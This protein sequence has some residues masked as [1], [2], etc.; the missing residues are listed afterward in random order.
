MTRCSPMFTRPL[1]RLVASLLLVSTAHAGDFQLQ[2]SKADGSPAADTVV[3]LQPAAGWSSP[4]PPPDAVVIGQKDLRF[5]PYVTVVTTG[6]TVR[7]ANQ[8]RYDHHV[9]A[10]AG[11]PLGNIPPAK[12][13]ELRLDGLTPTRTSSAEVKMDQAGTVTLGCHIHGSMRG[14]VFVSNSPWV[15]VTD[16]KGQ[17]T[18]KGVP[19]GVVELRLWHPDQLSDQAPQKLQSSS[20]PQTVKASL[21]FSPR[22][23]RVP[24][25]STYVDGGS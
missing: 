18:V 1:T 22:K 8:D 11:G 3:V 5:W 15:A 23:R 12:S 24:A 21:N 20:A 17:A 25:P 16:D 2:L 4:P 7:F 13:F 14:H 19:D 10:M 6:T 9:R